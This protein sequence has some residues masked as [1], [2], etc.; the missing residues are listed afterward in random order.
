MPSNRSKCCDEALKVACPHKCSKFKHIMKPGKWIH[1]NL[2][3]DE[4][5]KICWALCNNIN[6]KRIN[7]HESCT[8]TETLESAIET[9]ETL[10]ML[11]CIQQNDGD[12]A[13]KRS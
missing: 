10:T 6:R 12:V 4:Q 7:N 5:C 11:L 13:W 3:E 1:E 8:E 2:T 9:E